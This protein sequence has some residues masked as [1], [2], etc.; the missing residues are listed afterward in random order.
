MVRF[1]LFALIET[2]TDYQN[3]QR[4]PPPI[5]FRQK[6]YLTNPRVG[7]KY[8]VKAVTVALSRLASSR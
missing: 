4:R 3:C 7:K 8:R 2:P 1:E 6:R 5:Q